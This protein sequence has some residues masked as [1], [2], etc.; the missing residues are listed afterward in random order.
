RDVV[1][2]GAADTWSHRRGVSRVELK[3][4]S[5]GRDR[6]TIAR[7]TAVAEPRPSTLVGPARAATAVDPFA[8]LRAR[9]YGRLDLQGEGY[10]D[11]KGAGLDARETVMTATRS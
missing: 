3:S 5:R 11:Y 2:T 9:E 4:L 6:R 7:V 10:L 8:A 1:R